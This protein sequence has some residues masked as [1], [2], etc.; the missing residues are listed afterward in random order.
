MENSAS[1]ITFNIQ[2]YSVHDGP[3]IRTVVFFKGCQLRCRWCSNPES[4]LL[5]LQLG[6][7]PQNC[8]GAECR[9]C[10]AMC[11]QK[12]IVFSESAVQINRTICNQCQQCVAV[13]PSQALKTFGDSST[14]KQILDEV[15]ED[16][17]FYRRSKGGLTLSG[18]EACLQPIFAIELLEE[19]KSRG[20]NTAIETC[21][22]APWENV[23]AVTRLCDHIF[24]DI[25]HMDDDKHKAYTGVSNQLI[26]ENFNKLVKIFPQKNIMVRTPVVPGFNDTEAEIHAIKQFL[27]QVAPRVRYELLQYHR[28]GEEKYRCLGLKY[29][30]GTITLPDE[31]FA[32]IKDSLTFPNAIK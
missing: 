27:A 26:L 14:V 9:R 2:H 4:Q 1:G 11:G 18:G 17:L 28:F 5:S 31:T 6:Y 22:Y 23:Q 32:R 25:K 24:F 15:E 16:R 8:I 19:A 30:M 7:Q 10:E 12:A 3:G 13:C 20:I 21:G 29:Q